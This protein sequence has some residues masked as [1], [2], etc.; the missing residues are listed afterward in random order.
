MISTNLARIDR[1]TSQLKNVKAASAKGAKIG[2]Q[3]MLTGGGGLL[4]G[5][6]D[7]KFSKIP[8]TNVDTAGVIGGLGVIVAMSGFLDEN[9][10]NIGA[11]SGG[12]LA[13]VLG[14]EAKEYFL[15]R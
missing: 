12:M 7:A 8:N 10:D 4:A 3:Q 11:A 6:I 2:L 5:V 1:L 14:R 15:S 9:S 13:Y